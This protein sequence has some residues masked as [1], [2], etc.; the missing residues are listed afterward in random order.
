VGVGAAVGFVVGVGVGLVVGGGG[1]WVGFVVAFGFDEAVGW[2][3]GEVLGVGVVL[4]VF[5]WL[6]S[7]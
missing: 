3:L 2:L 5:G 4:S 6:L 1:L 7:R